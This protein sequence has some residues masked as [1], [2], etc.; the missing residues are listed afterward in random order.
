MSEVYKKY[1]NILFAVVDFCIAILVYLFVSRFWTS[2]Y[3]IP[4]KEFIIQIFTY[5]FVVVFFMFLFKVYKKEFGYTGY[6]GIFYIFSV[7]LFANV[8]YYL[9]S[10][11]PIF[12]SYF[13]QKNTYNRSRRKRADH[14]F[15]FK[16][17]KFSKL[18]NNRVC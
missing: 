14:L 17:D 16:A 6:D 1:K 10:F 18:Q 12:Q 9:L 2:S 3:I 13:G 8:I 4:E 5:S 11:I 7:S 15:I